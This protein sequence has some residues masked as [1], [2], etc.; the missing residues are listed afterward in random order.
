MERISCKGR[1]TPA[2]A[3]KSGNG[4]CLRSSMRDH[5][6]A[7]GEKMIR[8][9]WK[10]GKQGSPPRM[11]GKAKETGRTGTM[12]RITP[13]CAGKSGISY[14][15]AR[16]SADHPRV[17]GEKDEGWNGLA[18][19]GGSPPRVRG[20]AHLHYNCRRAR[21]ITPACAGKSVSARRICRS[22][23]DHPRV[24]GEKRG[25]YVNRFSLRGSP[26]R[27]RGKVSLVPWKTP[28]V[29]ITP[30]CAG[31]RPRRQSPPSVPEDHPR[32]C[33]EKNVE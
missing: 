7:C 6:R 5:P 10:R 11:R 31:K 32:V 27:V 8:S 25:D 23:Q 14:L 21:R 26:P 30:A 29:R 2:H 33:G 28:F 13:A 24:C 22:F 16:I 4:S 19:K 1:I 18:A 3:G 15:D 17:C 12:L 20:K 9:I